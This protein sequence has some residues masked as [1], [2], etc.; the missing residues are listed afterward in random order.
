MH[1]HGGPREEWRDRNQCTPEVGTDGGRLYIY[2]VC[3]P[4]CRANAAIVRY[5]RARIEIAEALAEVQ[6]ALVDALTEVGE[7]W[8]E[9]DR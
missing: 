6:A 4:S 1:R 3:Q 2:V 5:E 7:A 8:A 9:L